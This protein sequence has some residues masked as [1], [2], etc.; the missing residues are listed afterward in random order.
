VGQDECAF[1]GNA[2][3]AAQGQHRLALDLVAEHGDGRE[4]GFQGQLVGGEQCA[5][6][7]GEIL[8]A[9]LAAEP[10]STI[11][12]AAIVGVEAAAVRANRLA[13]RVRPADLAEHRFR[14]FVRHAEHLSEAQGL[15][16]RGKEE[17]LGHLPT[18]T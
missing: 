9:S 5:G 4:V 16:C 8:P 7:D 12:A 6:G 14:L 17:V 15:R 10:G 13:V 18:S 11:R 1:V 2:E 3:I